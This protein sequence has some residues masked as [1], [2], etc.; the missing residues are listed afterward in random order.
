MK[1]LN[2]TGY[3]LLGLDMYTKKLL[4]NAAYIV[5]I[6]TD[7]KTTTVFTRTGTHQVDGDVT[8]PLMFQLTGG[9]A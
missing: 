4:I 5:R 3:K 7:G 9:E 8:R 1:F 6:S 2:L